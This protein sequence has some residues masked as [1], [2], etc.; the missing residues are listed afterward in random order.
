M[1]TAS[2]EV[3]KIGCESQNKKL[4]PQQSCHSCV[5]RRQAIYMHISLVLPSASR[6]QAAPMTAWLLG[7]AKPSNHV[8]VALLAGKDILGALLP[9]SSNSVPPIVCSGAVIHTANW[10]CLVLEGRGYVE[11]VFVTNSFRLLTNSFSCSAYFSWHP[12]GV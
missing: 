2:I 5:H 9:G 10:S 11:A 7:R 6:L 8:W 4:S 1:Y 3:W 12:H